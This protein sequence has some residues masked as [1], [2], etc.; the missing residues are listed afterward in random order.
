MPHAFNKFNSC[1]I[2][3]KYVSGVTDDTNT[4]GTGIVAVSW[5]CG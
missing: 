5:C 3:A 2:K 1:Q 4:Y